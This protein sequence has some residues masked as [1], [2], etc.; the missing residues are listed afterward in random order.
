MT[1]G[2][3][4][5]IPF[6]DNICSYCDF[7]KV[8]YN[9]ELVEKYL[10]MLKKELQE[11]DQRNCY[12]SI[13]IGGG[14]PSSLSC[15]QLRTL[16]EMIKP[17]VNDHTKEITMEVNPESMTMEKLV[18]IQNVVNRLSIGV[19]TFHD[20]LLKGI[21]RLHTKE[22]VFGLITN[23]QIV[24]IQ[25]I[26]IDL[27][28]GLPNQTFDN[29]KEDLVIVANLAI[30]HISYYSLILEDHTVLKNKNYVPL[31]ELQ[32]IEYNLYIDQEL[33]NLGFSKYEIS[34]YARKGFESKHNS[35]YWKYEDY[36]GVGCGAVGKIDNQCITHTKNVFQYCKE[37]V[38]N[39]DVNSNEDMMFEHIMMSLRLVRGLDIKEFNQRYGVDFLQIYQKALD[40]HLSLGTLTLKEA[41]ICC[42]KESILYL[43]SILIDFMG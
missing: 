35:L 33:E 11:L 7:C 36:D 17:F 26:S 12:E 8:Y 38:L 2:L 29:I 43:N 21:E 22:Q 34:N 23:A 4:I 40:K 15:E 16:M 10:E 28:Y 32:D 41:F 39:I 13:Y 24:G 5:H 6:C 31:E 18:I 42:N 1:K 25:N 20:S 37:N 14:T 19:Q 9:Q 30:Q 3:Y 27:M